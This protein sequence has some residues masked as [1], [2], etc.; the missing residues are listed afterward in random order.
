MQSATLQID[1]LPVP[2]STVQLQLTP[3]A[4]P[5]GGIVWVL[6]AFALVQ[7]PQGP[8]PRPFASFHAPD[9]TVLAHLAWGLCVW[10]EWSPQQVPVQGLPVD[11]PPV[12]SLIDLVQTQIPGAGQTPDGIGLE[13]LLTESFERRLQALLDACGADSPARVVLV[14]SNNPTAGALTRAGK[15]GVPYA[16]IPDPADGAEHP[17]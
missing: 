15:A 5:A 1:H 2:G 12:P 3:A 16:V 4:S 8:Q 6:Q 17:E 9:P 7:T 13:S 10:R 11:A 14:L